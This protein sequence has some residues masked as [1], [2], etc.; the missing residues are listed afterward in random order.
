MHLR[1]SVESERSRSLHADQT[2]KGELH[3]LIQMNR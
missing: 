3:S 2:K 1:G